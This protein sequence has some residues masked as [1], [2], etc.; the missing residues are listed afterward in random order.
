MNFPEITIDLREGSRAIRGL[1]DF[2]NDNYFDEGKIPTAVAACSGGCSRSLETT[3]YLQSRNIPTPL[4]WNYQSGEI[5]GL[6]FSNLQMRET[7]VKGKRINLMVLC[8]YPEYDFDYQKN[9][10]K[11]LELVYRKIPTI[12]LMG[13]EGVFENMFKPREK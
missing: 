12:F 9:A 2:I 13:G 8:Q 10:I 5:M 7:E 4:N 6:S 11:Q 3:R 1:N